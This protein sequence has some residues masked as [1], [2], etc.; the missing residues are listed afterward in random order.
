M[1]VLDLPRI[2]LNTQV[3]INKIVETITPDV[4]TFTYTCDKI[5]PINTS[6]RLIMENIRKEFLHQAIERD[7]TTV[8]DVQERINKML[9]DN[10]VGGSKT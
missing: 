2:N 3:R 1:H 5:A 8:D 6:V 9:R 7:W 10:V 4:V